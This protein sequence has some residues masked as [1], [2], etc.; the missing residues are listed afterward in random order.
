M[1]N[2]SDMLKPSEIRGYR[3]NLRTVLGKDCRCASCQVQD[4]LEGGVRRNARLAIAVLSWVL[5]ERHDAS[6][7]IETVAKLAHEMRAKAAK[8][9][10]TCQQ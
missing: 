1:A 10:G 2:D 6:G 8:D 4:A 9:G 3:D 7:T 5:G